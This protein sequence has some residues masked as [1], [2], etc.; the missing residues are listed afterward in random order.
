MIATRHVAHFLAFLFV[1]IFAIVPVRGQNPQAIAVEPGDLS[2]KPNLVGREVV[3]DDRISRFQYHPETGFDEIFLKR[4]PEVT[5]AL[6]PGLR[7]SQNPSVVAVRIRGILQHKEGRWWV[8]VSAYEPQPA[9]LDRLNREVAILSS[10]KADVEKRAAWARWAERRAEVFDDKALLNR[11]KEVEADA[12]RAES[13]RP[14]L[15]NPA[16]FWL[17]LADRAR[18]RKIPEPEP[19]AQAHRGFRAALTST[20][21][22]DELKSLIAGIERVLPDAKQPL[23]NPVDVSRWDRPYANAPADA[24]RRAPAEARR[25]FDHRLW[26]DAKQ[27]ELE[28]R[29]QESPDWLLSLAEEAGKVLPDR[30]E[31]ATG[32]LQRGLL[33]AEARVGSLRQ[34]E[35]DSLA[36]LYREQ[37]RQPEKAKEL[38]RAWLNDQRDHR[39][40]PRDAEGRIALAEQYETLLDD[41]NSALSLLRDAWTVDPESRE[42]ADAFRR[43]GFRKIKGEWVEGGASKAAQEPST[44]QADASEE[45]SPPAVAVVAPTAPVEARSDSLRGSS[46]EEVRIRMGGRPN[47]KIWVASQGQLMEQWIYYGPRLNQYVNILH[48]PGDPQP[49]VASYYSLPRRAGDPSSAP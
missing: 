15:V 39:L 46:R 37:L 2:R 6:P 25:V 43:R 3:V 45:A 38:Y 44:T 49:R 5:F 8:D 32:F 31:L 26:A 20:K 17:A 13:D 10:S 40:S 9:D 35:V 24:Y 4:A 41:R 7:P 36:K 18:A 33:S 48:R 30:P 42:V 14:P 11:A 28:W 23:A 29:A 34:S 12:L 1:G 19:S 47:R 27:R 22:V 21:T 16:A